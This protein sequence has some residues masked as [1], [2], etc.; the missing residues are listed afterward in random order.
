V[1][2]SSHGV[3]VEAKLNDELDCRDERR[4]PHII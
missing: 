2:I 4:G 3:V 1:F